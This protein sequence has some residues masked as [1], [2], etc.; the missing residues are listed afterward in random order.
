MWLQFSNSPHMEHIPFEGPSRP[1]INC[2][3]NTLIFGSTYD[4]HTS[5]KCVTATP[6]ERL[7]LMDLVE[8]ALE[9]SNNLSKQLRLGFRGI[10]F[11]IQP[12]RQSQIA[13]ESEDATP[14]GICPA[15]VPSTVTKGSLQHLNNRGYLG[16]S[17]AD[18]TH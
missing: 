10:N 12:P 13:F 14:W 18:P 8:Y 16:L 4:R 3:R 2:Q 7:R 6:L 9:A 15:R 5:L 17:G 1:S 11:P